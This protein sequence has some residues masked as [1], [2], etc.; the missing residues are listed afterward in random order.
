MNTRV[1]LRGDSVPNA[2]AELTKMLDQVC[3]QLPHDY[4]RQLVRGVVRL[5]IEMGFV[6]DVRE[7][8][9]RRSGEYPAIS[10][11]VPQRGDA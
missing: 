6:A 9:Q 4:T 11:M 8:L 1:P 5:K 7:Y 3:A 2:D 10:P